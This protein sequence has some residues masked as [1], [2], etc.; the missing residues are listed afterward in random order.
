[1]GDEQH[2]ALVKFAVFTRFHQ[3]TVATLIDYRQLSVWQI[4]YLEMLSNSQVIHSNLIGCR[5]EGGIAFV[6]VNLQRLPIL[7]VQITGNDVERGNA[8]FTFIV[9]KA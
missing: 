5:V 7:K 3:K 8:W 6:V 9:D 4:T 1:M 2:I